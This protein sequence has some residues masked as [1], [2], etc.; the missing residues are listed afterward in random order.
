MK[1]IKLINKIFKKKFWMLFYGGLSWLNYIK[2]VV[3]CIPNKTIECFSVLRKQMTI[4]WPT[5]KNISKFEQLNLCFNAVKYHESFRFFKRN[6]CHSFYSQK[7]KKNLLT[8]KFHEEQ[9]ICF[10]S[11]LK[12]VDH[13]FSAFSFN[14]KLISSNTWKLSTKNR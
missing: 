6:D 10:A 7:T 8:N 4:K 5:L 2:L 1:F 13:S 11:S 3:F 14:Y 12:H 9:L